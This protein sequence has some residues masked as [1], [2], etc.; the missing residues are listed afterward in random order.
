MPS[1][2]SVPVATPPAQPAKCG[3]QSVQGHPRGRV[4]HM[5]ASVLFEPGSTYSFVSSYFASYLDMPRGYLNIHF[6]VSTPIGDSIIVDHMYH[7]CVVTV[8]GYETRIDFLLLNM[9]DFEVILGMDWLSSCHAILDCHDKTVM[10]MMPRL[11][12]LEWKGSVGHSPK[13]ISFLK[14]QW[15]IEKGCLA[16]LAFVRD[17]SADTTTF[18]SVAVVR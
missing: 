14:A 7:P 3:A 4:C 9:V 15:M 2:V 8:G 1:M 13:V 18:D 6:H 5:D 12:R 16:Y 17:V 10:L 11:P